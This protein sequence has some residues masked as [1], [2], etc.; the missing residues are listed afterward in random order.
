MKTD[1]R[2]NSVKKLEQRI[3]YHVNNEDYFKTINRIFARLIIRL[4]EEKKSLKVFLEEVNNKHN[5]TIT[6]QNLY[7]T[8]NR[9]KPLDSES[10]YFLHREVL[11]LTFSSE[12]LDLCTQLNV[13]LDVIYEDVIDRYFYRSESLAWNVVVKPLKKCPFYLHNNGVRINYN[14]I[15]NKCRLLDAETYNADLLSSKYIKNILGMEKTP[16]FFRFSIDAYYFTNSNWDNLDA[17]TIG[18]FIFDL[19]NT[20]RDEFK[21]VIDKLK[22]VENLYFHILK[23]ECE[24]YQLYLTNTLGDTRYVLDGSKDDQKDETK[25]FHK[26]IF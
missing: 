21:P 11:K 18:S 17:K 10:V 14:F 23:E 3:L 2:L 5:T 1:K 22:D 25:I 12:M 8:V 26:T 20:I 16:T 15:D 24:P 7:D 13:D 4:K 9:I 6:I 19:K